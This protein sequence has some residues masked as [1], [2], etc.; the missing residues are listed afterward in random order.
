MMKTEK[1]YLEYPYLCITYGGVLLHC[2]YHFVTWVINEFTVII[3]WLFM[4]W[5]LIGVHGRSFHLISFQKQ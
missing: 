5:L 2:A 1:V 3:S 4:S